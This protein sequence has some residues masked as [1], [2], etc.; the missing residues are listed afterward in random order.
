M[1]F[2]RSNSSFYQLSVIA[3]EYPTNGSVIQWMVQG[4]SSI[5]SQTLLKYPSWE[6][7]AKVLG[8]TIKIYFN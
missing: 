6:N 3:A 5:W 8:A 2:G 1:D 4:R 7:R